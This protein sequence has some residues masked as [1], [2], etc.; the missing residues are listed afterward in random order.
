MAI[1][2]RT[3]GQILVTVFGK[4]LTTKEVDIYQ[5]LITTGEPVSLPLDPMS[6]GAYDW[7]TVRDRSGKIIGQVQGDETDPS[8]ELSFSVL[9]DFFYLASEYVY[10][11]SK[12]R[13]LNIFNGETFINEGDK[14]VPI[15]T[16]GTD[17]S[18]TAMAKTREMNLPYKY[19][20]FNEGSRIK[21]NGTA[22][23]NG[24]A[25]FRKN[26]FES[27]FNQTHKTVCMEFRTT[28][29]EG[30]VCKMLP[31]V[32]KSTAEWAEGD[33]NQFN[34]TAQRGCDVWERD[35]FWT[36]VYKE[37]V[38]EEG[39]G[40][41][42]VDYI[43]NA[44][45]TEPTV[46]EDGSV[47]CTVALDGSVTFKFKGTGTGVLPVAKTGLRIKSNKVVKTGSVVSDVN[48]FVAIGADNKA[49][50]FSTEASVAKFYAVVFDLN[51]NTGVFEE[52]VTEQ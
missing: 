26:P 8:G 24:L 27:S 33:T 14:I 6:S 34:L 32:A 5:N 51:K 17:K 52:Y 16:N 18:K 29:G 28:T 42:Y 10:G 3:G 31:I 11:A 13:L 15:G 48:T 47:I 1:A 9:D 2:N 49:V 44:G 21:E 12:N 22:D 19:L 25:T 43:V 4:N 50:R 20:L 36:E 38:I 46:A 23:E 30:Q 39:A 45:A 37:D 35:D 7:I 40:E 41:A